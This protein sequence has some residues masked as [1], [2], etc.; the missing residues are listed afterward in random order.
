LTVYEILQEWDMLFFSMM[1]DCGRSAQYWIHFL[2][3]AF[4]GGSGSWGRNLEDYDMPIDYGGFSSCV[5]CIFSSHHFWTLSF[6]LY[7][8]K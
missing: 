8:R 7:L 2:G 5:N 3:H 6:R 1:C 4:M